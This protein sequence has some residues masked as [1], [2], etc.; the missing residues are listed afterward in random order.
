MFDDNPTARRSA[1]KLRS[2]LGLVLSLALLTMFGCGSDGNNDAPTGPTKSQVIASAGPGGSISPAGTTKVPATLSVVYT[3]TPD[4]GY[5]VSDVKIDGFSF[6]AITSFEFNAGGHTIHATFTNNPTTAVVKLVTIDPLGTG[7]PI[8][9]IESTLS[10]SQNLGL[11]IA[12]ADVVKSG[13]GTAAGTTLL[14]TVDEVNFPGLVGISLSNLTGI[15]FGEFATA[16][17]TLLPS[18]AGPIA[19]GNVPSPANFA[20]LFEGAAVTDLN[21]AVIPGAFTFVGPVIIK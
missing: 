13:N 2:L 21:G 17:F 3:I 20:I 1:M 11:S 5:T 9:G 8:G 15:G 12:P 4:E 14:A 19:D 16:T 10:F 18:A 7:T 6:G